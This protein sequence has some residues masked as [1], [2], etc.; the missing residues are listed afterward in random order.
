MIEAP[1]SKFKT[2]CNVFLKLLSKL[3]NSQT[4]SDVARG[5]KPGYFIQA[6]YKDFQGGFL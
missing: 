1:N 3:A 2:F 6:Q 5:G 4:T